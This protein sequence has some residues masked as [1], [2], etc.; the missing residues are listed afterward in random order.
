MNQLDNLIKQLKQ[1]PYADMC[2]LAKTINEQLEERCGGLN[3]T[4]VNI[5]DV[6][7]GLK[8]GI[9]KQSE[10]TTLEQKIIREIF[11]RKRSIAVS[12][13]GSGYEMEISTVPG[14]LVHGLDLR[15]MFPQMLDQ[16]TTLSA[17]KK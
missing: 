14:S 1:L 16:I 17:M 11:N 2:Q 9:V 8:P 15:V 6:L 7:A 13:H 5:A 10:M 3:L 12:Q 4:F